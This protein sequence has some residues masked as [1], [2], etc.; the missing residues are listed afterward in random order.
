[1][2]LLSL[3]GLSLFTLGADAVASIP[4]G[5]VGNLVTDLGKE[6]TRALVERAGRG[7][8]A[9]NH[10]LLRATRRAALRATSLLVRQLRLALAAERYENRTDAIAWC[11]RCG[12]W[13]EEEW[14]QTRQPDYRCPP[15]ALDH[16]Y[17]LLVR[18]YESPGDTCT[19]LAE[20]QTAL[21]DQIQAEIAA[22]HA[23]ERRQT[24]TAPGFAA[25]APPARLR[26][27]LLDGWPFVEEPAPP[28]KHL[29]AF[30]TRRRGGAARM[31][32]RHRAA[33]APPGPD[34]A[35]TWFALFAAL[36]AE[37]LKT[38]AR[39]QA[40]FTAKLLADLHARNPG[41]VEP[42]AALRAS[43]ATHARDICDRLDQLESLLAER[44]HA[45]LDQ[46]LQ[47]QTRAER[48]ALL[49][50]EIRDDARAARA[51]VDAAN[52]TLATLPE[53][54]ADRVV[55]KLASTA[56]AAPLFRPPPRARAGEYFGHAELL[57]RLTARL[58]A[59]VERTLVIGPA[60]FG[61]TALAAEALHAVAPAAADLPA[62]PYPHGL[63]WLDLYTHRASL[64]A[65]LSALADALRGP[66]FEPQRSPAERARR[67]CHA[68]GFLLILEGAELFDGREGRPALRE[69]EAVLDRPANR[70]LVLTRD[71]TQGTGCADDTLS[72]EDPLAPP[73][74][75]ALLRRVLGPD[76][77]LPPDQEKDLLAL[78]AGHPLAIT[79]TGG[80]LRLDERRA[81]PARLID[82][83]RA[84][85]VSL[86]LHDPR[87]AGHTLRWLF[88]RSVAAL[89]PEALRALSA[90]GALAHAPV[91]EALLLPLFADA[92]ARAQA[93]LALRHREL[94]RRPTDDACWQFSHVLAYGYAREDH[95]PAADLALALGTALQAEFA[96]LLRT[97]PADAL[98][99]LSGH[100]P[101]AA[102]LLDSVPEPRP[103]W[104]LANQL[105]YALGDLAEERGNLDVAAR[106]LAA[107]AR[108]WDRLPAPTQA[109]PAW[110][111]EKSAWAS[112][113]GNLHVAQ[114]RLDR[115]LAAFEQAK[116][117]R[118]RL[119]ASDPQNAGW[120]RDLSVSL[121]KLGDLHVAQ[122]RLDLA[123]AA[124]EQAKAIREG[125]AASAPQNAGWQRDLSVSLNR[126]GDLHVAQGRLDLA[127][128]AFDQTKSIC[129]RLAASDPQNA[130]WQRDLQIS[131]ERLAGLCARQGRL[132]EAEVH[133]RA[134]LAL[135]RRLVALAPDHAEF[136]VSLIS[137]LA[138]FAIH[139]A[140]RPEPAA[141][142][143][144]RAL[145]TEAIALHE[146]LAAAGTFTNQRQLAWGDD[147]RARL[148]ALPPA[149]GATPADA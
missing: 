124:F 52:A 43:L 9:P 17:A 48:D 126:L 11:D 41:G 144:A 64:D 76:R 109:E 146:R 3:I 12:E 119:A 79:W 130:G 83:W 27:R 120:Q 122:G 36:F 71:R 80:E 149:D 117:I 56:P 132:G 51:G 8:L 42:V 55:E 102:A 81:A 20:L 139:L 70:L 116:I 135:A 112:R 26:A 25:D 99:R 94:L 7:E 142:A 104:P 108:W 53:R 1:M 47:L 31:A 24:P 6:A 14:I 5:V 38:D 37:E 30:L 133:F 49:L 140:G 138:Q 85:G 114:G 88:S 62:G 136:L 78:L 22:W 111:R 95:R 137:S 89:A 125:L 143:E 101:H 100:L 39:V 110:Q 18:V 60:G 44:H 61:K 66:D 96:A 131:Y 32:R 123:L 33:S 118:E 16:D 4:G 106:L 34:Q 90:L 113:L 92:A 107:F 2:D 67:A 59:G 28:Q 134:A 68:R 77:P 63:L 65:A 148:A 10:D 58:R 75:A 105:L 13:L 121:I 21:V 54:T 69:L 87:H 72:L 129:A 141:G 23:R 73:D 35:V 98:A 19:G 147:L 128:A 86:S 40:I 45:L 103:H 29:L 145:F 46:F 74:A 97:R 82:E 15:S 57:A 91:P 127:L 93:L 115:A 50:R 84:G